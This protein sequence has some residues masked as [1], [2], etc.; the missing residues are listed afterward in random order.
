M[1]V[2]SLSLPVLHYK[3]GKENNTLYK[4]D[5]AFIYDIGLLWG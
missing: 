2:K 3:N 4:G 1:S 5:N